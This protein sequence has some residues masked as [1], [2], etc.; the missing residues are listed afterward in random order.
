MAGTYGQEEKHSRRV[1]R[2]R[3]FSKGK[4]NN[5]LFRSVYL[6]FSIRLIP[7]ADLFA[8]RY[9]WNAYVTRIN[10]VSSHI[11]PQTFYSRR[12]ACLL[13]LFKF[14]RIACLLKL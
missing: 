5:S 4:F 10:A 12:L 11:A 3:L 2:G 1:L 14:A 9:L 13:G 6:V 7:I 8:V